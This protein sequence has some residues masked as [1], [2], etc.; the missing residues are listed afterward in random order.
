MKNDCLLAYDK[1]SDRLKILISKGKKRT[2]LPINREKDVNQYSSSERVES[3]I[4]P[5]LY[6]ALPQEIL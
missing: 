1:A 5:L 4:P 3:K 2:H 6:S